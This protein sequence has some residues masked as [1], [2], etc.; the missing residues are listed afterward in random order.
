MDICI[1]TLGCKVNQYESGVIVAKLQKAGFNAF[2][3]LK[4]ADLYI[5]NTCAVTSEAEKKS[6]QSV[7]KM[8]KLN[9]DCKIFVIGCASQNN[10]EQFKKYVNV[11]FIKGVASKT[12]IIDLIE[13]EGVFVDE[14]PLNYEKTDFAKITKTRQT[15]K[16]QEGCNNFCSYCLIPYLRGRSRSRSI[17][18]IVTEVVEC[19][20]KVNEIVLTGIDI[21][22]YGKSFGSSLGELIKILDEKVDVRLRIGSLE[23]NVINDEFLQTVSGCKN[24]CPHFHLS[25]QSGSDGVLKKMNRHY[26]TEQYMQK[27][28][29]I[30]KY[31][32][33]AGITTD[34][35]VGFPEESEQ[36]F[37]ETCDFAKKVAFSDIH[38]FPYSVRKG[39]VAEK[40]KQVNDNDKKQRG[41][42]LSEIKFQLKK[43]FLSKYLNKEMQILTEDI[44]GDYIAGYT[45][46][47]IKVYLDKKG[48]KENTLYTVK[49]IG[50][51]NDGL[52]SEVIE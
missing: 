30:R 25:L 8:V 39:T 44:D 23:V 52:F 21:S 4:K 35:I 38:V 40:M 42:K 24:F 9:P 48:I 46:N 26:T 6:R 3:G 45:A 49:T 50:L 36:M 37:A 20:D 12:D 34:I 32:P 15:I 5:I 29:L 28:E 16:I 51:F 43:E 19:K 7:A 41:E 22:S 11:K 27:V 2:E 13:K 10:A 31:F 17:D 33:D 18:D 47:Y 14:L 1:Y